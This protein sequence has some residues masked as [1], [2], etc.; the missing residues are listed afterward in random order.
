MFWFK[1]RKNGVAAQITQANLPNKIDEVTVDEEY[2]FTWDVG[3]RILI[4]HVKKTGTVFEY[5]AG[6]DTWANRTTASYPVEWSERNTI[7]E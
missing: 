5:K 1:N 7:I 6:F 3:G 2:Y 4:C